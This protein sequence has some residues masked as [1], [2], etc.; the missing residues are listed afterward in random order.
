MLVLRPHPTDA[1][2]KYDDWIARHGTCARLDPSK[3][4]VEAIARCAWVAGMESNAMVVALAAQRRVVCTLPP[5]AP[6]CRLPHRGLIH[7]KERVAR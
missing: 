3:S 6:P 7:L 1:P 5:W 4:L 2:G